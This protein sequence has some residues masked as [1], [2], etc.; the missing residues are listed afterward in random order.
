MKSRFI[1][2]ALIACL[3][4]RA[5]AQSNDDLYF[6][7]KK[8]AKAKKENVAVQREKRQSS[9]TTVYAA[10]GSTVVVKDASGRTMNII[11]D[12][13]RAII[14]SAL[15]TILSTSKKNLMASVVNG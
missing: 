8:E 11:A 6:V 14:L 9:A 2:T 15:R 1:I 5:M 4:W 13:H 3:P 10:P 12:T 7:P